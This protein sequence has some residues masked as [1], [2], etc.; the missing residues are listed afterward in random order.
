[1]RRGRSLRE[2]RDA[3][4]RNV[5]DA[6][7]RRKIIKRKISANRKAWLE[8]R[9]PVKNDVVEP[10]TD[11]STPPK[12]IRQP[13]PRAVQQA[14]TIHHKN[15]PRQPSNEI[16]P[17]SSPFELTFLPIEDYR[18]THSRSATVCHVIESLGMGGAQVM[19]MELINGLKNYFG[20]EIVNHFVYL[21][22]STKFDDKLFASYSCIPSMCRQGDF[23][24]FC[25]DNQVDIVVQHRISNSVCIKSYL[26]KNVKYVLVNHSWNMLS[27]LSLFKYCDLYISVCDFLKDRFLLDPQ[28][29]E[30][31]RISILNGI[32]NNYIDDLAVYDVGDSFAI[33]RCHR[34]SNGKF[35]ADSLRWMAT[36]LTSIPS[37]KHYLIG[38]N[39]EAKAICKKHSCLE[40]LGPMMNRDKKMSVIKALDVYFYETF[41]HE[42]ASIAILEALAC[43]VPVLCKPLGGCPEL[44]IN[45]R[46]GFMAQDRSDFALRLKQLSSDD[47]LLAKMHIAT[48]HDFDARLHVRH[49]ANKYVQIFER[50]MPSVKSKDVDT[51]ELL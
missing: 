1:M 7:D 36:K 49:A 41:Q 2:H 4:I 5:V 44:V 8:K 50:L 48:K 17:A 11:P 31:R 12:A 20:T 29:H 18:W 25:T 30:S 47:A 19:T 23:N 16:V 28:I 27:R 38:H 9:L 10:P 15:R 35:K 51:D 43:G 22:K 37:L 32:E 24:K 14:R 46:N 34:L 33:G 45:G 39:V 3:L 26:P 40:Y 13:S 42:G 21:G 6:S